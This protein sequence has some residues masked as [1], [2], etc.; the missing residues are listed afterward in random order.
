VFWSGS[1]IKRKIKQLSSAHKNFLGGEHHTKV[2][3]RQHW[4][5]GLLLVSR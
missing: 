3:G 2:T 4:F 1:C 5:A